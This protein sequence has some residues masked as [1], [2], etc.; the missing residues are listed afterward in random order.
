VNLGV[1]ASDDADHAFPA[2]ATPD[3]AWSSHL[4]EIG[5]NTRLKDT[6]TDTRLG[7]PQQ[8]KGT[9]IVRDTKKSSQTA[10]T[11]KNQAYA[12]HTP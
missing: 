9:N 10:Y 7:R 3:H 6:T 12:A 2:K 8:Q 5:K 11:T 1:A 4:C